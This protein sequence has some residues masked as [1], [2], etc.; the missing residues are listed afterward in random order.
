[1]ENEELK[2]RLK[3]AENDY[4][5]AKIVI[6]K[7]Y[8]YANNPYK[9]GD[10]VTDH[11]GSLE[12]MAIKVSISF[13]ESECIYEGVNLKKDGKPEKKQGR[14]VHQSNVIPAL[15]KFI[16]PSQSGH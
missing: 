5:R 10:I 7:D 13:G 4:E 6:Y 9:I 11:V 1:M 8:A 15:T 12:I 3:R 14:P 2:D 16:N